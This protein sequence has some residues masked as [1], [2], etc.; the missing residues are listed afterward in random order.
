[1]GLEE[2]G[3]RSRNR[4]EKELRREQI[5]EAAM[6]EFRLHGF[7]KTTMSAVAKRAGQSRGLVNF[8]FTDKSGLYNALEARA[9]HVLSSAFAEADD[10]NASGRDRLH[11]TICAYMDFYFNHPEYFHLLG[12]WEDEAANNPLGLEVQSNDVLGHVIAVIEAGR[13]DG[14]LAMASDDVRHD[15]ILLWASLHGCLLIADR[16]SRMLSSH[17]S[18]DPRKLLDDIPAFVL[19]R[20]EKK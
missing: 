8:Y 15:A 19:H 3:A 14:T 12:E 20:L 17:L 10:P 1:M 6:V 11:A 9:L 13:K 16:K 7:E 4:E 18:I 5:L 2:L